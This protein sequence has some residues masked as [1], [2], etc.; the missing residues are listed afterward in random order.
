MK[1]SVMRVLCMFDLPTTT[2]AEQKAYRKFR[3]AIINEGFYMVQFSVYARTCPNREFANR[4]ETRIK[5]Y[6][7]KQGNVRLLTVTEKQYTEMKLLVGKV[8][9][10][11]KIGS[12]R[13]V[14]I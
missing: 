6:V 4:L 13:L 10:T 3:T 14:I 5:K 2:K 7:P 11:E 12:E 9:S 8:S 1:Y